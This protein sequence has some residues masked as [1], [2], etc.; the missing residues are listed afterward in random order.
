MRGMI[1]K[2]IPAIMLLLLLAPAA[3]AGEKTGL[4]FGPPANASI[5]YA[6]SQNAASLLEY[7]DDD[8][9]YNVADNTSLTSDFTITKSGERD[10]EAEYTLNINALRLTRNFGTDADRFRLEVDNDKTK[11]FRNGKL[12]ADTESNLHLEIISAE[13]RALSVTNRPARILVKPNGIITGEPLAGDRDLAILRFFIA[14]MSERTALFGFQLPDN[15][16]S[17]GEEWSEKKPMKTVGRI[18]ISKG[19]K[20]ESVCRYRLEK[21]EEVEGR[22][23]ATVTLDAPLEVENISA[24]MPGFDNMQRVEKPIWIKKI[25]RRLKGTL[26]HDLGRNAPVSATLKTETKV[27]VLVGPEPTEPENGSSGKKEE[28]KK[29]KPS[30]KKEF[31][32]KP[33][34]A[35]PEIKIRFTSSVEYKEKK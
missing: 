11:L 4:V 2:V 12:Y 16:V 22:R 31:T 10:N 14:Y 6:V 27:E 13:Q 34:P 17:P 18:T 15:A 26:V 25:S 29:E 9:D 35:A 21:I 8:G 7:S 30:D 23:L 20:L 19:S 1:H 32:P 5:T 3:G 24:T 28:V 33:P